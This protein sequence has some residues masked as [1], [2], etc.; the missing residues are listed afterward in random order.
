MH[1]PR[2]LIYLNVTWRFTR[3]LKLMFSAPREG[4]RLEGGAGERYLHGL[5]NGLC[6]RLLGQQSNFPANFMCGSDFR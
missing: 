5:D 1:F 4:C 3:T 6:G 2:I